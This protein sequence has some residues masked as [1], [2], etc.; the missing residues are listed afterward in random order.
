MISSPTTESFPISQSSTNN[1]LSADIDISS[2]Q[3]YLKLLVEEGVEIPIGLLIDVQT[4]LKRLDNVSKL[5]PV[6]FKTTSYDV[7]AQIDSSALSLI[8]RGNN[9]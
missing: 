8:I 5:S 1:N 4:T 9:P 2:L 3:S 6:T 7:L